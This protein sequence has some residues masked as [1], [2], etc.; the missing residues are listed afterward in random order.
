MT[1]KLPVSQL[2]T[3][4]QH[5]KELSSLHRIMPPKTAQHKKKKVGLQ[6]DL[7]Q[8]TEEKAGD[9]ISDKLHQSLRA[10]AFN[11]QILSLLRRFASLWCI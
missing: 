7:W 8:T 9:E 11:M 2:F 10:Q 6:R 1:Y 4:L 5:W 3:R